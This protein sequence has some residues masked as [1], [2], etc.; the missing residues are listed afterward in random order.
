MAGPPLGA[1]TAVVLHPTLFVIGALVH[2][3]S[4][5]YEVSGFPAVVVGSVPL[6]LVGGAAVGFIGGAGV[7]LLDRF[8]GERPNGRTDAALA[9]SVT[10]LVTGL[11]ALVVL[12]SIGVQQA[13]DVAFWILP[14]PV[15]AVVA[16]SAAGRI[17]FTTRDLV[18]AEPERQPPLTSAPPRP[19]SD[20]L[21][22]PA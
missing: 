19:A 21:W 4:G 17:W 9:A 14:V 8:V 18:A 22:S 2:R 7:W 20:V 5:A 11:F 13:W 12:S 16:A 10:G 15:S 3:G 6:G 1:L